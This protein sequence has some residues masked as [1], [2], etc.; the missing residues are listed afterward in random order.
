MSQKDKDSACWVAVLLAGLAL[1]V[2]A[3]FSI[4]AAIKDSQ[5]L[6]KML[7]EW[8]S[9]LAGFLAFVAS[10]M[11]FFSA[12]YSD[13]SRRRSRLLSARAFLPQ[14]LVKISDYLEKSALFLAYEYCLDVGV[15]DNE[16]NGKFA[17]PEFPAGAFADFRVLVEVSD[18]R[19]ALVIA[20]LI[21]DL[22]VLQSRVSTVGTRRDLRPL[23][24]QKHGLEIAAVLFVHCVVNRFYDY[25]R[26]QI[27][28]DF[29]MVEGWEM[30]ERLGGV[31]RE[32]SGF[33][34]S[35]DDL[36]EGYE[37]VIE[38]RSPETGFFSK[39]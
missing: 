10:L 1:G 37:T 39:V 38:K 9:L 6:K 28:F 35:Y 22:Q 36:I 8:Q 4:Y 21:A 24:G 14:S 11:L 2:V 30:Q 32:V 27:D 26:D 12:V 5:E 3:G 16:Q 31:R 13:F 20:R 19:L 18:K 15:A 33:A 23:F 29:R 17:R 25:S 34:L 7:Y